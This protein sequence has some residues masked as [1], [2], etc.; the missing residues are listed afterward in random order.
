MLILDPDPIFT[1]V[2]LETTHHPRKRTV[3]YSVRRT[4]TCDATRIISSRSRGPLL[5]GSKRCSQADLRLPVMMYTQDDNP[6]E[7]RIPAW[8]RL[9]R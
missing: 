2:P 9:C 3:R 6:P 7:G 1:R 4:E 5:S 8:Q